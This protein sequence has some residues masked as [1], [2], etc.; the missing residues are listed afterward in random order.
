MTE[1]PWNARER[2]FFVL[3]VAIALMVFFSSFLSYFLNAWNRYIGYTENS[4]YYFF[5]SFFPLSFFP[6]AYFTS[7]IFTAAC[8]LARA[9][10]YRFPPARKV[11]K[12][13]KRRR[14]FCGWME[15]VIEFKRAVRYRADKSVRLIRWRWQWLK[16]FPNTQH[17]VTPFIFRN[18][19]GKKWK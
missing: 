2:R 13:R 18:D 11:R 14:I 12:R 17:N 15:N 7:E 16:L 19:L 1:W 9:S 6:L 8:R 5:F 10:R 4:S 3:P